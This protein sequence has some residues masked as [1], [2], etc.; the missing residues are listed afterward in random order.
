M[1]ASAHACCGQAHGFECL[2]GHPRVQA[3]FRRLEMDIQRRMVLGGMAA[4]VGLYA[5]F[6]TSPL[7]MAEAPKRDPR[8]LL[9]TNL[10]L[11]DGHRLELQQGRAVLVGGDRIKDVIAADAAPE[12]V[13][14]IDCQGH[15]LM[16]GLI[17]AH[18][19]STL[20]GVSQVTAMTAD[21]AYVHLVAAREAERTLLRGFTTVRD[22]GGPAFALKQAI[23]EGVMAGPRIFPAGAMISQTSGHG[24]FRLLN[25]L[26]RAGDGD[27]S[28][29]ERAGVAAIA[30]GGDAV[31]RR[32]REQLMRGASQIKL[33]AGGGVAS[34]YDPLD[35]AQF[36]E[37]ELRAAV[38]AASDWGT[39]VTVHVYTPGGIQRAIRAGVR[40]IEHGQLADEETVRMMADHDIWW[41]LQPFLQ[42]EDANVYPDAARQALQAEVAEGTERAFELA[43]KHNVRT[44]FGTDILMS[45]GKTESQGRQLA[46]LTRWMEPLSVLRKATAGNGELLALSG[47]RAPYEG[48]LGVIEPGALA[49]LLLVDGNP[50]EDLTFLDTPDTS[51]KLILKGG[52]I[53]A[54]RL[55]GDAA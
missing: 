36:T 18:W 4:A 49:D 16:P 45:P 43:D 2:C 30:D 8:P 24:D 32:T 7:L 11:F 28:Y 14:R 52:G 17:D 53:H 22:V 25:E 20:C 12:N 23:D 5:G 35:S 19:H 15:V 40:C 44:G 47:D 55:D 13:R 26:P 21:I 27:L 51:L 1:A 31:L 34:P 29:T 3:G 9:L 50:E 41:S 48:K 6:G 42:D 39:Y 54:N 46:K 10:R 38:D 33:M 37:Q